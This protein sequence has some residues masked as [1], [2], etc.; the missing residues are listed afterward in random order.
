M[1]RTVWMSY[2]CT[3]AM[4]WCMAGGAWAQASE[5]AASDGEIVVTA[6]RR[7]TDLQSTAAAVTALSN[8]ALEARGVTSLES[9]G[10]A[11]PGV[12][13]AAYQGEASVFVRGIGTPIIV[14]GSE[15]STST[16]LDGVYLA[17]PAAAAASF[18]DLESV[19]VLRGPQG[20]LYGRNATGG[21][22]LLTSRA[23]AP[24][25]GGEARLTLG[26]YGRVG[27]FLAVEGPL[28]SEKVLGRLAL[29]TEQRD[30]YSTIERPDGAT[31]DVED[32]D[33]LTLRARIQ[34]A[35]SDALQ[36]DLIGDY[37]RADDAAN[38]FQYVG[39]GY[40]DLLADPSTYYTQFFPI[41]MPWLSVNAG[42]RQS[43]ALSRDE[44]GDLD[45]FNRPEI[46]GLT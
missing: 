40:A 23:P 14:G 12:Q 32:R 15:S 37:Y 22:V 1:S 3:T 27:A 44:Y 8:E 6:Q 11:T 18:F 24:V 28:G 35:P 46:W 34:I 36:I 43:P 10:V 39:R 5:D 9:L 30:G 17:R 45:Y 21:S 33:D 26:D 25:F 7:D 2:A 4:F 16:Y 13:I 42:G 29:Q 41:I 19:Q 31:T 38:V 20:T